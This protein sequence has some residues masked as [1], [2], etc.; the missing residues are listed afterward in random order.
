MVQKIIPDVISNQKL[1]KLDPDAS[2]KAA[3]S[4]MGSNRISAI[5]VLKNDRLIGIVTE[6]D[7]TAKVLANGLD[8][9]ATKI[10]E[11]MTPNPDCLSPNDSPNSALQ[12]MSERGYRHLPVLDGEE[13]VGMVSIRDLY[14]YV[15]SN[16]EEDVR[17]RDAFMFESGYGAGN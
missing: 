17:Q 15:K 16:L 3:A 12:I 8:P 5:L 10:S 13:V 11:V 9:E 4:L 6:R 7:M 1:Q 14:A 2:V